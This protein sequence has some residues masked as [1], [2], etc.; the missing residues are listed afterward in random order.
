MKIKKIITGGCSFSDKWTYQAW[1][2]RLEEELKKDYPEL[3]FTHTGM[4]SQGQELIQ[5]KCSLAVIEE[6]E[7]YEPEELAVIVMWS[8]TE[9]K[10]FYV[11][12][13]DY[14]KDIVNQWSERSLSWG[15][16]FSDLRSDI[17]RHKKKTSIVSD[18]KTTSYNPEGGWYI[19][20]YLMP[21]SKLTD[22]YFRTMSTPIGAVTISLEN[23]VML[24]NLC[25]LK[26]VKM[27]HMFYRNYVYND[28][29]KYKDHL[30]L[31]YLYKQLDSDTIISK[32]G[33]SEYLRPIDENDHIQFPFGNVFQ[34]VYK[35]GKRTDDSLKYFEDDHQHP[36]HLGHTK[37][38]NEVM[39][40]VLKNKGFFE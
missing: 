7:K 34:Y 18:I 11:D 40:P 22:E 13:T 25:K 31:N 15:N 10:T 30:N 17:S 14:I 36:N 19:C 3:S 26:G 29:E 38:T 27:Y 28:I 35:F 24:Q 23:M 33:I 20:N 37:W 16:Q 1:P 5:K 6:L 12:D 32:I 39:I 9:R 8:G 21:D 4:G 2:Y